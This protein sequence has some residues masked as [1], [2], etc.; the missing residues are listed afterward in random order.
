MTVSCRSP[1][2]GS[3]PHTRGARRRHR[4]RHPRS[5]IIPAYAGSTPGACTTAASST[6]HPR[7][8][9]EHAD[10]RTGFAIARGSSPHTRGA[11]ATSRAPAI[12]HRIIPA[13]AG[14]TGGPLDGS[15][16]DWDHPRIRGEHYLPKEADIFEGGSSPHTRGALAGS[17]GGPMSS[18][19]IPAYAGSTWRAWFATMRHRD[20][21]RIRGEH[22]LV[23]TDGILKPGSSPHTRGAHLRRQKDRAPQRIIPAY[24]GSTAPR[25]DGAEDDEDHPRIRGEHEFDL[26]CDAELLGSSPHTRGA[27]RPDSRSRSR[28]RIIPAYAGSTRRRTA[29][30]WKPRDHPR[31]RGEHWLSSPSIRISG[32]SSPH[33]RGAPRQPPPLAYLIRDHPRIRG[34]HLTRPSLYVIAAGSSPHTRGAHTSWSSVDSWCRIIPAYAGSTESLP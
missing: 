21:P 11:L 22:N 3:S 16:L 1:R 31:I 9:G 14:S 7:I 27:R 2:E 8:R 5:R 17:G 20:H 25:P 34:E 33:T 4:H 24:A 12:R 19:I 32:G 18:R 28:A 6:D 10:G 29:P 23:H 15:Y 26:A 30:G 13:Y